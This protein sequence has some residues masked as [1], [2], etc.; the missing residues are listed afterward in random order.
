M[1][2]QITLLRDGIPLGIYLLLAAVALAT[3]ASVLATVL[4][5]GPGNEKTLRVTA[6]VLSVMGLAVAGYV[7]YKTQILNEV[8]QCVGGGG[9]CALVEKSDYSE[10]AG[11][12]V[13]IFG[14]IGYA[15]ILAA[16]I[17]KDDLARVAAFV[18]SFFGFGFSMYLTYLELWD[19]KAICQWCVASAVLMTLLFVVN[20]TRA[21]SYYGL[22]D[23]SDS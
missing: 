16:T 12:H 7:I 2:D 11:V 9:G 23:E 14:F 4:R 3:I 15:L 6:G 22:D 8:P 20:T 18:L 21:L 19:I 10:L 13:S 17:W 1:N 5:T